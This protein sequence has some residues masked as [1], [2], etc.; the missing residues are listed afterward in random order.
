MNSY[1]PPPVLASDEVPP[2]PAPKK[3]RHG[4]LW[5]LLISFVLMVILGITGLLVV[6]SLL[7]S[8]VRNYTAT[9]P[10][11]IPIMETSKEE[12][13]EISDRAKKFFED[14][15]KGE[16][17]EP[18]MLTT[19]DLNRLIAAS[20]TNQLAGKLVVDVQDGKIKGRISFSLD[21]THQ[22]E[23][24]GRYLNADVVLRVALAGGELRVWADE[25][26]AN[27]KAIPGLLMS[28]LKQRNLAEQFMNN[29]DAYA[30]LQLVESITVTNGAIIVTPKP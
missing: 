12:A 18:M 26:Q 3:K 14:L 4:C 21:Q 19:D 5:A 6:R 8:A 20:G 7:K 30:A 16:V 17:V 10:V 1:E 23:L 13:K 15:Q 28:N 2:A 25:I 9:E 11:P 24:Q 29:P 22:R 27:D